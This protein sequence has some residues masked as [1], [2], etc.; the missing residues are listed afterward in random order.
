MPADL[1]SRQRSR[2]IQPKSV[3]SSVKH[4]LDP[5]QEPLLPASIHHDLR[6][7]ALPVRS[8]HTDGKADTILDPRERA[9]HRDTATASNGQK[10]VVSPSTRVSTPHRQR[11][12]NRWARLYDPMKSSMRVPVPMRPL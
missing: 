8:A 6:R 9:V 5:G 12:M 11:Q 1:Q 4:S 2:W 7:P 3:A 10:A